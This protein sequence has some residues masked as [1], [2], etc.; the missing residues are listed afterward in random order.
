MI[1]L[2]ALG[3][4]PPATHAQ[5]T[6]RV[7]RIGFI[8]SGGAGGTGHV[9]ETLKLRLRELGYVEGRTAV[10]ETRWAEGNADRLPAMAAELVRLNVD[11][12]FAFGTPAAMAAKGAT[13]TIPIVVYGVGDPV[14]AGLVASLARP[15]GNVTGASTMTGDL[16]A[17]MVELLILV[18]P[19]VKRFGVL[20]NPIN[21]STL[22]QMKEIE[23]GARSLGLQ[24]QRIE[25]RSPAEIDSGLAGMAKAGSTSILVMPDAVFLNQR[26]QIAE[27][28]IR[29]RIPSI[30]ARREY[31][32]A[33]GLVSYGPSY[34]E[35]V[36]IVSDHAD[37]IFKGAKPAELP[38]ELPTKVELVINQ[39]TA[40]TIGLTIP[41]E[42]L[43]RA[44]E[45]IQ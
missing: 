44:D 33:G 11:L 36:R 23:S 24:L 16:S 42:L 31:V 40:R 13:R 4:V 17:K 35:G 30:F 20:L 9:L 15:G 19:Q 10:F 18:D 43:I 34:L 6:R 5:P 22:R 28:T 26:I 21:P 45:V 25:A 39:K 38:V 2:L 14:G 32:E 37:K 7:L 1:A 8:A 27:H 12:V 29:L 41:R 3:A